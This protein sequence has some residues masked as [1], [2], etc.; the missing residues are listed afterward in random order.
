MA[1]TE[2]STTV[3]SPRAGASSRAAGP[4]VQARSPG[5]VFSPPSSE[6]PGREL[7][8]ELSGPGSR[9][10]LNPPH[11][12]G[13]LAEAPLEVLDARRFGLAAAAASQLPAQRLAPF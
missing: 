1:D 9:G 8:L 7:Q 6:A 5:L 3:C 10:P 13:E 4:A 2:C 11:P 12:S